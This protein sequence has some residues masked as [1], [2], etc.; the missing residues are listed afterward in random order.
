MTVIIVPNDIC[1]PFNETNYKVHT[2]DIAC[3]ATCTIAGVY[4]I[5]SVA[6]FNCNIDL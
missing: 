3:V 2:H 6:H 1:K 4:I 5:A